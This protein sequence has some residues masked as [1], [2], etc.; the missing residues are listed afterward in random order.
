MINPINICTRM[1]SGA[2]RAL[3]DNLRPRFT[4][5]PK[6]WAK[7]DW[8]YQGAGEYEVHSVRS[9]KDGTELK[10]WVMRVDNPRGTMFYAHGFSSCAKDLLEH[11]R[12]ARNK[13]HMCSVGWD[14]RMHGNSGNG[15]LS[16]G[17]NESFDVEALVCKA[18][19]L[20][21]PRPYII[22]GVS[23][24]G[25]TAR[26]A[27]RRIPQIDGAIIIQAPASPNVAIATAA[28]AG[29]LVR[30]LLENAS[31]DDVLR[32]GD[33]E[34]CRLQPHA[35][36]LILEVLG[37]QDHY[38]YEASVRTFETWPDHKAYN[39]N[40]GDPKWQNNRYF[41]LD[42]IDCVH[43]EPGRD[44]QKFW[45]YPE[46]HV[47]SAALIERVIREY[48]ERVAANDPDLVWDFWREGDYY[49]SIGDYAKAFELYSKSAESGNDWGL[50][51]VAKCHDYGL[52]VPLNKRK[53][54]EYYR[55]SAAMGNDWAAKYGGWMDAHEAYIRMTDGEPYDPSDAS[56][57]EI[58]EYAADQGRQ[59]EER[60]DQ[61][62]LRGAM[63]IANSSFITPPFSWEFGG[64]IF[65]A[66]GVYVN[67]CCHFDD[68][69]P[70]YIGRNV[71]FGPGVHIFTSQDAPEGN[72]MKVAKPVVIGDNCW[73]CGKVTIYPGVKIGA[74]AV[75]A[76][77]S[78]VV[79]DV[80]A[81]ALVE[82]NP[83]KVERVIEQ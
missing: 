82:G 74:G 75:V 19:E 29:S 27:A 58:R 80:P 24:G 79:E 56:L 18:R 17:Y 9:A 26:I 47:F 49:F 1:M 33:P 57:R 64:N 42:L 31:G 36:P 2:S 39:V 13:L 25:M 46:F 3:L 76:A 60:E 51:N 16:F 66:D 67:K 11:G 55:R 68:S 34:H 72:G 28:P 41:R 20:G 40:P 12:W 45:D 78:V 10:A 81:N 8:I 44:G 70:I 30:A 69:A 48:A 50:F 22:Q 35:H 63:H 62:I 23:L 37:T 65:M 77:G 15:P 21:L 5:V 59:F 6:N 83:A 53:A 43:P 71:I 4:D 73:I 14:A 61:G 52:G 38:G 54:Q 7:K 32:K